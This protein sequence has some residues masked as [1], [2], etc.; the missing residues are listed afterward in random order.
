MRLG[1]SLLVMLLIACQ[2]GWPWHWPPP[3]AWERNDKF[4]FKQCSHVPPQPTP[5][6]ANTRNKQCVG[7]NINLTQ[8][9]VASPHNS[10]LFLF[11]LSHE[12]ESERI[13]CAQLGGGWGMLEINF[14][15]LTMQAIKERVEEDGW[16]GT[17]ADWLHK[18]YQIN[19]LL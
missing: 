14:L 18:Q 2:P 10:H 19:L 1:C 13:C 8:I 3:P 6:P 4:Y 12:H 15:K 16:V 11:K 17:E 5:S 7:P 9:Y